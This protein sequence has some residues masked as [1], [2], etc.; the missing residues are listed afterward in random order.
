MANPHPQLTTTLSD[1]YRIERQLGGGGMATVLLAQD[2][3][4]EQRV[5]IKTSALSRRAAESA[6]PDQSGGVDD[7]TAQATA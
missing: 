1:R 3:K 2:L 6:G 5:A 7:A 4:Q